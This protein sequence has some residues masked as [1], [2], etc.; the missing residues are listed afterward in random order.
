MDALEPDNPMILGGI[1][2]LIRSDSRIQP[3]P[4][5]ICRVL[6]IG[7]SWFPCILSSIPGVLST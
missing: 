4:H 3:Q 6:N 2:N 5:E 7:L 1:W